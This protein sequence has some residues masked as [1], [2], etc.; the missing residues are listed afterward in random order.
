MLR[1]PKRGLRS[2]QNNMMA[3]QMDSFLASAVAHLTRA[4][5]AFDN[6]DLAFGIAFAILFSALALAAFFELAKHRPFIAPA[7]RIAERL[8]GLAGVENDPS[9]RIA[10]ADEAFSRYP[11]LE[12]LWC[13]YRQDLQPNPHGP[14]WLNLIDAR[15][16]FSV[17]ALPGRGYEQWCA[18]W[19]GVFLTVGLLF[20]FLGLS[21]ALLKVGSITDADSAAMK[22]AISGI[23]GV[24]SA[25]FIT[26]LAGLIAYIGFSLLTRHYQSRQQI[27]AASLAAAVQSLSRPLTPERLL[28]EQRI[29]ADKQ[30]LRL[31]RLT[32]DLAIAIDQRLKDRLNDLSERLGAD[33]VQ[34]RTALPAATAEPIVAAINQVSGRIAE[35]NTEGLGGLLERVAELAKELTTIKDGMGGVGKDFGAQ[36]AEAAGQLARAAGN[37]EQS[38]ARGS[39]ELEK[40]IDDSRDRLEAIARTLGD[41]PTQVSEALSRALERLAS[42]VDDLVGKLGQGGV[43]GADA[44]RQGGEA[45]GDGLKQAASQAGGAF[46]TAVRQAGDHLTAEL[47]ALLNRLDTALGGLTI[48]LQTIEGSLKALPDAVAGQIQQLH[49]TG[50]TFEK[51][52]GVV[53]NASTSIQRAAEPLERTATALTRSLAAVEQQIA[54]A[55]EIQQQTGRSVETALEGLRSAA[56]AAERTFSLHEERFGQADEAL[57]EALENLRNGVEAVATATQQVF[58]EYEQ[59]IQSA[60]GNLSAWAQGMEDTVADLSG[61]VNDLRKAIAGRAR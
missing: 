9:T 46:D 25:K 29:A 59:H 15:T 11:R 44:I 42:A 23:L 4:I 27:A 31:E 16:W 61:A 53:A 30:L 26:S 55:T 43:A 38:M 48:R 45:A 47:T 20:T 36:I 56:D 21:A 35:S 2:T 33:L 34:V 17:D 52:G 12:A 1:A 54:R 51:A 19:A 10:A 50:Q 13:D 28:Y 7:R 37:I 6:P 49:Y 22:A 18:T 14:G 5:A 58:G 8:V 40:K 3:L 32:D 60:V 57:A 41:V 39:S 24:S